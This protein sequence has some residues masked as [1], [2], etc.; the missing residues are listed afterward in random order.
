MRGTRSRAGPPKDEEDGFEKPKKTG[1]YPKQTVQAE[2]KTS[3]G[4][5]TLSEE[6]SESDKEN[7]NKE[8]ETTQM[9]RK[10]QK[11]PNIYIQNSNP[12]QTIKTIKKADKNNLATI[13]ARED[14]LTINIQNKE[15]RMEILKALRE[16]KIEH[17]SH[18]TYEGKPRRT[19]IKYL[20]KEYTNEEIKQEL[21]SKKINVEAVNRLRNNK[22]E[23][24]EIIIVTASIKD[25]AELYKLKHIDGL[26]IKCEPL[27]YDGRPYQCHNCLSLGHSSYKC[28]RI[29]RC[30]YCAGAHKREDCPEQKNNNENKIKCVLCG[31]N[32]SA[33]YRGCEKYKNEKKRK[34][35][36]IKKNIITRTETNKTNED[37]YKITNPWSKTNKHKYT[38]EAESESSSDEDEENNYN[39]QFPKIKR[40]TTTKTK[41]PAIEEEDKIKMECVKI[42]TN[43][44]D[45]LSKTKNLK[46]TLKKITDFLNEL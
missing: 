27:R 17:Y 3:N 37:K 42:F 26:V 11:F 28:H 12:K 38:N 2:T 36:M 4:Y 32:H 25:T 29:T 39:R 5:E 18:Q 21:L 43:I 7:E 14:K 15:T 46:E 20:P 1:K 9:N 41:E 31:G 16:N 23:T 34:L 30:S 6:E 13:K 35:N 22:R 10:Q 44:A 40:K 19:V 24:T 33:L 45:K 8:E